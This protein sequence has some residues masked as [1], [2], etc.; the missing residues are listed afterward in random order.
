MLPIPLQINM[1]GGACLEEHTWGSMLV[2]D[3][4]GGYIN[5]VVNVFHFMVSNQSKLKNAI[6]KNE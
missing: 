1:L 6:L 3:C 5:I 2:G 4:I